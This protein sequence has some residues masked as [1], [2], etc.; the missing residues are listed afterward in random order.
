MSLDYPLRKCW[1]KRGQ[2]K[3][4]PA[5]TGQR[6]LVHLIGAYDWAS[7]ALHTLPVDRKAS[8]EF[9]AFLEYVC[10]QVYPDD[11]LVL[12][13]DNV[14]Y[15]RSAPVQAMISLLQPRVQ[16]FWLPTYSPDLNPIE[17]LW[18]H[19]KSTVYANR[20]YPSLAAL[21]AAVEVFLSAQNAPD[22]PLRLVSA[23]YFR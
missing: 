18:L 11:P 21:L 14:A 22:H 9:I 8:A 1:M 5:H 7:D 15:H 2:Q 6:T 16:V 12:V 10:L 23:K 20:L 3:R 19:L 13:M 4:V 17:R